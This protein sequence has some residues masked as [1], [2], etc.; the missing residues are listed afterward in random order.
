LVSPSLALPREEYKEH[1][2]LHQ[3]QEAEHEELHEDIK[4]DHRAA[5]QLPMTDEQHRRLHHQ[6]ENCYDSNR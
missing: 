3:S 6:L 4:A 2:T 5:H 1:R